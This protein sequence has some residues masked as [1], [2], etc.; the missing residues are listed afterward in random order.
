[1]LR[2]LEE[3]HGMDSA[4]TGVGVMPSDVTTVM[5]LPTF[6]LRDRIF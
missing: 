3:E 1:M 6:H 2:K 5:N 4:D